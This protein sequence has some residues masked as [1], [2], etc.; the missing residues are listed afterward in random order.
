MKKEEI[1][2][3]L[4]ENN[5]PEDYL[6]LIWDLSRDKMYPDLLLALS[7]NNQEELEYIAKGELADMIEETLNITIDPEDFDD[8]V[9]S[10]EDFIDNYASPLNPNRVLLPKSKIFPI[11]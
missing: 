9:I 2:K 1:Q 7:S 11:N 3:V 6:L 10:Y 8:E 4:K 5:I